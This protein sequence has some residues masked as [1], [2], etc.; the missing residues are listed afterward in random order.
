MTLEITTT[1]QFVWF[2]SMFL[3]VGLMLI[4]G[5]I[6]TL[7]FFVRLELRARYAVTNKRRHQ[8]TRAFAGAF[9]GTPTHPIRPVAG[10]YGASVVGT[11]PAHNPRQTPSSQ[12]SEPLRRQAGPRD[13]SPRG[14]PL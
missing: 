1:E 5:C 14:G 11:P 7:R 3:F 8:S 4:V 10:Q 9:K 13:W 6:T 12:S 2:W